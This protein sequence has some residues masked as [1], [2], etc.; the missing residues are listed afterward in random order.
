MIKLCD[1]I[2]AGFCGAAYVKI[3]CNFAAY[4]EYSKLA[5]FWTQTDNNQNP[6]AVLGM[7]DNN[8]QVS[9][10]ENCDYE[11][12]S[13]FI[14][15]LSPNSIFTEKENVEPLH[16]K[17]N[18][19][20]MVFLLDEFQNRTPIMENTYCGLEYLHGIL[21]RHL[22]IA[23]KD[24]FIADM[25]HRIRH[26]CATYVTGNFSAAAMLYSGKYGILNGIAVNP[27]SRKSGLGSAT[28]NRLLSGFRG[29]FFYVCCTQ[30]NAPF[31][32]KNGLKAV[33]KAAYCE[34]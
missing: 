11:E 18:E 3:L 13:A 16:L 7:L 25:S 32:M 26:N 5:L 29:E 33:G 27:E 24:A 17:I 10:K 12:L 6:T 9:C 14:K 21:S 30:N 2:P 34:V 8:L 4:G 1:K 20:C 19:E 28:L 22:N 23:E 15:A 31:Y